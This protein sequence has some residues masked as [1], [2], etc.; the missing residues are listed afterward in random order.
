MVTVSFFHYQSFHIV[1]VFGLSIH[2]LPERS[3]LSGVNNS[4]ADPVAWDSYVDQ[5][6]S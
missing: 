5:E 1:R 6:G 4:P 3:I 2:S